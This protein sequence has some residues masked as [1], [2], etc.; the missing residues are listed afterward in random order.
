MSLPTIWH[1][2]EAE[3]VDLM[4][5]V[6]H[7]CSCER[8]VRAAWSLDAIAERDRRDFERSLEAQAERLNRQ[9]DPRRDYGR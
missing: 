5:A 4:R 9:P 8:T 3:A 2:S 6:R 7:N 1:G